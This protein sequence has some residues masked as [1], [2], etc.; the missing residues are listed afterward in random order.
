MEIHPFFIVLQCLLTASLLALL[1][2]AIGKFFCIG[3][4][5]DIFDALSNEIDGVT[6]WLG[7]ISGCLMTITWIG[8]VLD[9]EILYVLFFVFGGMFGLVYWMFGIVILITE[10]IAPV[11]SEIHHNIRCRKGR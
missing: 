8:Y 11:L 6:I 3:W 2:L 9:I 4:M 1:L 7:I 10:V 5:E